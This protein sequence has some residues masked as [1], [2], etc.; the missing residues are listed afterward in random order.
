MQNKTANKNKNAKYAIAF[1]AVIVFV[2]FVLVRS[3]SLAFW[4]GIKSADSL[5]NAVL[6]IGKWQ[7]NIFL[8][9][10][11]FVYNAQ[12]AYTTGSFVKF[13]LSCYLRTGGATN[14]P[15]NGSGSDGWALVPNYNDLVGVAEWD[16]NLRWDWGGNLTGR[17]VSYHGEIYQRVSGSV[18]NISAVAPYTAPPSA[19]QEGWRRVLNYE[20][21][22]APIVWYADNHPST[23][24]FKFGEN[25]YTLFDSVWASASNPAV[26]TS[27]YRIVEPYSESTQYVKEGS[28]PW[29]LRQ[30]GNLNLRIHATTGSTETNDLRFWKISENFNLREGETVLGAVIGSPLASGN[31]EEVKH[32]CR[33]STVITTDN[34]GKRTVW[35]R[36][37]AGSTAPFLG[38]P[39]SAE[40]HAV[41]VARTFATTNAP[42]VWTHDREGYTL[43]R[44][45]Q[46][47][48]TTA[49]P[50]TNSAVWAV[51]LTSQN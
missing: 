15:P 40:W 22:N 49:V 5:S 2:L 23:Q 14:A 20:E 9:P 41:W 34:G 13:G 30:A 16:G 47:S 19:S 26:Q 18:P 21:T 43:W 4:G 7:E 27:H 10:P 44:N 25:Y 37:I 39:Y 42:F 1:I 45:T 36:R 29:R 48:S 24:I 35:E 6:K 50:S 12:Q 8:Y 17:I 31:W 33:V 11:Q 3:T 28:E 46:N 38:E 51:V 32:D